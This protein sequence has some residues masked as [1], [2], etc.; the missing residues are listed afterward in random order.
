MTAARAVWPLGHRSSHAVY[1]D[2][3][4]SSLARLRRFG[5]IQQLKPLGLRA[6]IGFMLSEALPQLTAAFGLPSGPW[7]Q[8]PGLQGIGNELIG[9]PSHRDE[10]GCR[11]L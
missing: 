10:G 1:R 3:A 6:L 8:A 11:L 5:P 2:G 4:S 9:L 7:V